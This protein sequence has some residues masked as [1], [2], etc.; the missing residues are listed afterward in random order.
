MYNA[1]LLR[2]K[3]ICVIIDMT[4]SIVYCYSDSDCFFY[5]E[6]DDGYPIRYALTGKTIKGDVVPFF[7]QFFD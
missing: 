4:Y 5:G 3:M 7:E 6:G 2:M 1:R